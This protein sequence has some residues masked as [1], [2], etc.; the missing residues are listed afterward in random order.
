VVPLPDELNSILLDDPSIVNPKSAIFQRVSL[1]VR[2][3]RTNNQSK[4][5]LGKTVARFFFRLT[6]FSL[7]RPF[8]AKSVQL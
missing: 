7:S 6:A 1:V 3:K 5:G 4:K 8:K 2:E